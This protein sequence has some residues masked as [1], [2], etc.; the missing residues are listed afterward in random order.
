[1]PDVRFTKRSCLTGQAR[2]LSNVAFP[3][4]FEESSACMQV[5]NSAPSWM[6]RIRFD[7]VVIAIFFQR[8]LP[9]P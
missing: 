8:I 9:T 3:S 2:R 7:G 4:R 5:S 1:V 6:A